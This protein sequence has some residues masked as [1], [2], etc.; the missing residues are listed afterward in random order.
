MTRRPFAITH[1][2]LLAWLAPF[3]CTP[4]EGANDRF[5]AETIVGSGAHAGEAGATAM[6][7]A[8][9]GGEGG[10]DTTPPCAAVA[11]RPVEDIG[12]T[13]QATELPAGTTFHCNQTYRL[14]GPT[15]VPA[16]TTLTIEPSVRVL[17]APG[18][19][20]LVQRGAKLEARGNAD[21]PIVFTSDRPLGER[22]PGDWRGLV[23]IGA[24][25][26]HTTSVPVYNTLTD[27][28][29]HFGGGPLADPDGSCGALAYVRIEFAGGNLDEAASPGA[30]LTLAG[31]GSGTTLDHVQVHRGTD[32]VGL[33]G[34]AAALSH[35]LVSYNQRGDCIEWTGGFTGT[36]AF[37]VGQSLGAASGMVG[38][39][40]EA[41]PKLEPVSNPRIYNATLV[42]SP[43][44]VSG[45][46]FGFLLQFGS[47]ATFKNSIVAGFAD[48]AFDIRLDDLESVLGPGRPIDISHALM[49]ENET[50]YSTRAQ[51][52]EGMLSMRRKEP[53]LD[54]AVRSEDPSFRPVSDTVRVE[55][56]PAPPP[57]DATAAYRGAVAPEG[58]DWTSG[59]TDYPPN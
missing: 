48:A 32:G 10:T 46:H 43:P 11:D 54:A 52:L 5:D 14:L 1:S 50:P 40:S 12:V 35:L 36:L 44:L 9:N 47:R 28:R 27:Y 56:A 26:T 38:S 3:S 13:G 39:N 21:A 2:L 49:D 33:F 16:G 59:W 57:F 24:G 25:R 15:L 17:A 34:G 30:S 37:V 7:E 58:D 51:A 23:L 19:M 45:S 42:G 53:G 31:C 6:S 8:G 20:L 55:I 22:K 41:D 29:A 4:L 18:S